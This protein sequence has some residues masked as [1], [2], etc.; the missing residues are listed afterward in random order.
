MAPES[1]RISSDFSNGKDPHIW[2]NVALWMDAVKVVEEALIALDKKNEAIY[3]EN[4][5][6]YLEEL[7]LLH[8]D[9]RRKIAAIP[10]NQRT[11]VTAHDAFGY[12]G[13]AYGFEVKASGVFWPH[14]DSDLYRLVEDRNASSDH[15]LVW[16]SLM[17][18]D[19]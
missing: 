10:V 5:K 7:K 18:A 15:R 2:F 19:N 16:V 8:E 3:R 12:F 4:T 11:L 6:I 13:R 17:L 14:K 1:L 9:T